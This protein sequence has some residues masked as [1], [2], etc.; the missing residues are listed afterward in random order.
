VPRDRP[1]S[2]ATDPALTANQPD[3]PRDRPN[4]PATDPALAANQPD[5]PRDRPNSPSTDPALT[6][7]RPGDP[8]GDRPDDLAADA[9]LA[10]GWARDRLAAALVEL[11]EAVEVASGEWW[12]R[13]LPAE[14]VAL[15]ERDGHRALARL[16]RH[17]TAPTLAA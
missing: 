3:D 6:A 2:P 13:A 16:V 10:A 8:M 17:L 5:D 4:S 15:A 7:D 12:Q 1:N 9:V 11:R 14:R